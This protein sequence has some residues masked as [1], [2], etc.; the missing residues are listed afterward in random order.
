MD[1]LNKTDKEKLRQF[2]LEKKEDIKEHDV[3][4]AIIK[5]KEK[6]PSLEKDIPS[7]LKKVWDAIVDMWNMLKDF[8]EGRYEMAW[9]TV[10]A[11]V[12]ALLYFISPID[13]IPDFIPAIGYLDDAA[14]IGF[15]LELIKDDLEK[16]REYKEGCN[17]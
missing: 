8:C 16:Y 14:V 6:I 11:I 1:R 15:V 3:D 10:T 7:T 4:K 17:V 2:L 13:F 5:G 12:A 9:K